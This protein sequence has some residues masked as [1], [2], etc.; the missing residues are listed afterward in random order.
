[1]MDARARRTR[2]WNAFWTSGTAHSCAPSFRLDGAD[3]VGGFWRDALLGLPQGARIVD[4]GTGNGGLLQLACS[5]QPAGARWQL[6]GVDLAEPVP[7][8]FDPARHGARLRFLGGTPMEALPLEDASVDLLLSQFGIEYAPRGVVQRECLRVLAGAGRFAFLLHHADSA[9]TRVAR[10]ELRAQDWLLSED[11][12]I[13]AT[14]GLLPHLAQARGG[15][16]PGADGD[17]ARLRFNAAMRETQSLA[18]RLAAPDLLAEAMAG[19]RGMLAHTAPETLAGQQE[20]L[21]G[22]AEQLRLARIRT[23][24]QLAC[25]L[26]SEG[27]DAFLSPFREAGC[28]VQ[29]APLEE[30]GHLVGWAVDGRRAS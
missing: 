16:T 7:A 30:A 28:T 18:D 1:M 17:R 9:I 20:L 8:W 13:A 15:Q 26:G 4:L 25:A 6:T 23:D 2:A 10:D 11:G 24:E 29:A 22:Y 12:P 19:I 21:A 3:G 5:L 14:A 27:I